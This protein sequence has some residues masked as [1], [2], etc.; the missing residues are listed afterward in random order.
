MTETTYTIGQLSRSVGIPR[1]TVRYYERR[2]ILRPASRTA[3][4]YR[5][6]DERSLSRLKF[7]RAAQT[8]GFSLDD[9]EAL[10]AL[11]DGNADACG[12]VRQIISD[13]LTTIREQIDQLQ[14]IESVLDRAMT[15]CESCSPTA[16]C[17]TLD[18][19]RSVG[20]DKEPNQTTSS[21]ASNQQSASS[22]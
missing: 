14:Q 18:E 3:H 2:G 7:I 19:L 9:I 10:L 12:D 17:D 13:R 20:G 16:G 15:R 11:R 5:K 8:T 1:S 22:C 4:N 6:Y 21:C